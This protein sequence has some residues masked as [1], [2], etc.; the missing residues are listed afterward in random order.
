MHH[1]RNSNHA[2]KGIATAILTTMLT[3]LVLFFFDFHYS[4]YPKTKKDIEVLESKLQNQNETLNK[5]ENRTQ[6]IYEIL[7]EK[8]K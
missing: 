6:R 1:G 4:Q 5:I 2:M 3:G 7:L 8:S